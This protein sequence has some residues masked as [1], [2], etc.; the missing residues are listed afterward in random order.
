MLPFDPGRVI[1]FV[2][3]HMKVW[4]PG[5]VLFSHAGI[6]ELRSAVLPNP[7][8]EFRYFRSQLAEYLCKLFVGV[9]FPPLNTRFFQTHYCAVARMIMR[10]GPQGERGK[11][12]ARCFV[13]FGLH[14]KPPSPC[15]DFAA[16][17]A[18]A[19]ADGQVDVLTPITFL[20]YGVLLPARTAGV[21]TSHGGKFAPHR[22]KAISANVPCLYGTRP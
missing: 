17:V 8:N 3:Q 19:T 9:E 22:A 11:P 18:L 7:F 5:F 12:R 14:A 20:H 10:V 4:Q 13:R 2:P 1:A 6:R 16:I 21:S 15:A